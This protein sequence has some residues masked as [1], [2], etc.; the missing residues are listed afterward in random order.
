[1]DFFGNVLAVLKG[2][3]Q[4]QPQ[5]QVTVSIPFKFN[6]TGGKPMLDKGLLMQVQ[7]RVFADPLWQPE[8]DGVTHCNQATLAVCQGVGCHVFDTPAGSEPL[9]ADQMYQTILKSGQ[10]IQKLMPDAIMLAREGV[11]IIAVLP[12]YK[13]AQNEG[14]I[15]TLTIGDPVFSGHWNANAPVVMNLGRKGT[16]FRS[17]GANYAFV[18]QPEFWVWKDT[19]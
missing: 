2:F 12:S 17:N 3:I 11:F 18:P 7:D 15:C 8:V 10:F 5:A 6:A 16:C 4:R 1:M 9:L 14:H 13:L 19:L